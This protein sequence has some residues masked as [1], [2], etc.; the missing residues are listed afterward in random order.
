MIYIYIKELF[1]VDLKNLNQM[2]YILYFIL[3]LVFFF[4]QNFILERFSYIGF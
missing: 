1:F 3:H 2:Y 4:T